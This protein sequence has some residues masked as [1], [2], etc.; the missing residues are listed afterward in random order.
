MRK[1]PSWM[2]DRIPNKYLNHMIYHS[3][4]S[5]ITIFTMLQEK[6][7]HNL[8]WT[9]FLVFLFYY[10]V[11]PNN[12]A[13][14]IPLSRNSRP[15]MSCKK[16]VLRNFSKFAGKHRCQSLFF[17]KVA[18]MRP[19]TLFKKRLWHRCLPEACN[20]IKKRY[21]DTARSGTRAASDYLRNFSL[22][23]ISLAQ[24]VVLKS[25]KLCWITYVR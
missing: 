15:E 17:N 10:L 12:F 13:I 8:W 7:P 14:S 4:K 9:L 2:S 1:A 20:L 19:E 25:R 5:P 6:A 16:G 24:N 23:L 11:L 3:L 21:S 18:G 22:D